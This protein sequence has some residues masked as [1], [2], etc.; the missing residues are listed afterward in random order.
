MRDIEV[1]IEKLKEAGE[2][3]FS[4]LNFGE[5]T[6]TNERGREYKR[7]LLTEEAFTLVAMSYTTPEAMKMKVRFIERDEQTA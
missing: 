2:H 7:F 3:E 5:S 6:Y 1:Q 4:L